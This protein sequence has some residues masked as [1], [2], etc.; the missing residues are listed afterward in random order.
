ME[1]PLKLTASHL[2]GRWAI[3]MSDHSDIHPEVMADVH[4]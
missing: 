2:R 4:K 1:K 3:Q